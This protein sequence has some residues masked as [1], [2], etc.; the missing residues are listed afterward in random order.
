MAAFYGSKHEHGLNFMGRYRSAI[1]HYKI[2]L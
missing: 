2:H 1:G